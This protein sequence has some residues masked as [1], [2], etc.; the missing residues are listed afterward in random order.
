MRLE[1]DLIKQIDKKLS[2]YNLTG[3][4][5]FYLRIN[6]GTVKTY[7]CSYV[8]LASKGTPDY[9]ALIRGRDNNILAL[10]IE[11]KSDTG[12]LRPDQE[13]F[14]QKHGYKEGFWF[15]ELRDI[16]ELDYWIEKHAKNFID[17]LP[18]NLKDI[19]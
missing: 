18:S 8:K 11:A 4:V 17:M 6:S 16:K 19:K 13:K 1:K 5:E 2:L 12:K 3:E 10:F 14:K 9:L 7:F 15:M